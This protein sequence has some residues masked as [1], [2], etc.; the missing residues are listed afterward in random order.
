LIRSLHYTAE[1]SCS[2]HTCTLTRCA[3]QSPRS[4]AIRFS[5]AMSA[6]RVHVRTL[7]L[8]ACGVTIA[9]G[10]DYACCY[11]MILGRVRG[12]FQKYQHLSK[13]G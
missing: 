13:H 9:F 11:S 7:A 3:G 10:S 6:M 8:A 5:A 1:T 4:A 12:T 2:R